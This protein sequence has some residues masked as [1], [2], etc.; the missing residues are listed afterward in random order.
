MIDDT[1]ESPL[2][3]EIV[4]KTLE[5]ISRSDHFD[6][7]TLKNI[8]ELMESNNLT[9]SQKIIDSIRLSADN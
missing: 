2:F 7:A 1:P 6:E 4:A 9:N 5:S 8:S 3:D